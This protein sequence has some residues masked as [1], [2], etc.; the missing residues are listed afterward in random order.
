MLP[1]DNGCGHRDLGNAGAQPKPILAQLGEGMRLRTLFA[2]ALL[3]PLPCFAGNNGGGGARASCTV[4]VGI[5]LRE[6]VSPKGIRWDEATFLP[7]LSKL[8][9]KAVASGQ[10]EVK[11]VDS[12]GVAIAARVSDSNLIVYYN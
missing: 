8:R 9:A 6:P 2:V 3:F 7:G 12:N 1:A 10:G 5:V 11:G 4:S